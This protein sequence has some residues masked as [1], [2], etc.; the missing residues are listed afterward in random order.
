M[1][2]SLTGTPCCATNRICSTDDDA[3][4][5]PSTREILESISRLC[6][7]FDDAYWSR[8]DEQARF[9]IEFVEAITQGGWL[10]IAM[11]AEYGGA[12]LGLTEAAVM[13]QAIAESGAGSVSLGP[14][15]PWP[16]THAVNAS[17]C[18]TDRPAPRCRRTTLTSRPR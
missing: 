6:Q 18:A 12:G 11:P 13:M 14:V 3:M 17:A 10:G 16:G 9:P 7:P 4:T 2:S 5:S 15:S 8:A 1:D